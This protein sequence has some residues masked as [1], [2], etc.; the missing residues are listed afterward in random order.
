MSA[1][2]VRYLICGFLKET[3]P[4]SLARFLSIPQESPKCQTE[5]VFDKRTG[6]CI[7]CAFV[8]LPKSM[9]ETL[10]WHDGQNITP[11]HKLQI[12]LDDPH[13]MSRCVKNMHDANGSMGRMHW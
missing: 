3:L 4:S 12:L 1:D 7:G 2:K 6:W 8:T 11:C 10:I 5:V 9:A 13:P